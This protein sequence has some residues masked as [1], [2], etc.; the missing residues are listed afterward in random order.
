VYGIL[1]LIKEEAP[2]PTPTPTPTTTPTPAPSS[3]SSSTSSTPT[4][5]PTPV[6][7]DNGIIR[8][9]ATVDAATGTASV[10][11]DMA[12]LTGAMEKTA[13]QPNGVKTASLSVPKADGAEAYEV[14][15]PI[16]VLSTPEQKMEIRVQTE[17]GEVLLPSGMLQQEMD[18]AGDEVALTIT[19]PDLTTL[20]EATRTAIG[21]RPVIR[22]SLH[23]AGNPVSWKNEDAPVTVN[24]PYT[25]TAAELADPEHITI[26]YLDGQGN[27]VQ[28]P[29]GRYDPKT[30]TVQFKT[31]HFS[32]YAVVFVTKTFDDME[33]AAWAQKAVEVLASK[34]ALEGETA[35]LFNPDTTI[36]RA[37]FTSWLVK[38]L[39]LSA[40]AGENFADVPAG[41]A[42]AQDAAVA[43]K[44]GVANGTGNNQFMPDAV[45]SRQDMMVLVDRAL[46]QTG[47][48]L[49]SGSANALQRFK[50]GE[51]VA[52]YAL[53]SVAALVEDGLAVGNAGMINP[54]GTTT[55]AEAAVLLYRI[56]NK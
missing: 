43:R 4:P 53:N 49:T 2:E 16:S 20:D 31:T 25:P 19:K 10:T 41:A 22:L 21:N 15:L 44:L 45:I 17:F 39:G 9:V 28:V 18:S 35:A 55:R 13:A 33:S 42:Y 12:T 38:T 5:V 36:T 30:G 48:E 1:T 54:L 56:Y 47:V 51:I 26:W 11:M 8:A 50:D 37:A 46:K 6:V 3:N 7:A 40:S 52:E 29:S 14:V 34:G 23:V 24:I 27:A 32:N